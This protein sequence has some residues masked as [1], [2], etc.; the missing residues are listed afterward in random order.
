MDYYENFLDDTILLHRIIDK[1][2]DK[3]YDLS[4]DVT[5]LCKK[6]I[7]DVFTMKYD[8]CKKN[9]F[10]CI[11]NYNYLII[12][13]FDGN[14]IFKNNF[15]YRLIEQENDMNF[16]LIKNMLENNLWKINDDKKMMSPLNIKKLNNNF[17][18][19][20]LINDSSEDVTNHYTK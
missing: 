5:N 14:Y 1:F 15:D 7:K 9:D 12:F 17:L 11:K 10:I 13:N 2:D 4:E 3:T 20:K 16:D 8:I 18:Y 6:V 19:K